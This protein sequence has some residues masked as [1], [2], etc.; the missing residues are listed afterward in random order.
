VPEG[1]RL[2]PPAPPAAQAMFGP[3]LGL[4]ERYAELLAG[5]GVQR[6]LLGPREVP[7]L[8][9]RHLMNC[10]AVAELVPHPCSLV[11]IG[12]GAGLPGIVLAMLLPDVQVVLLEPML[13]RASF[14]GECT[15]LLGLGNTAI[16]RSR[17]QDA[18]GTITADVATARAVAPMER[19]AELALNLVRPGGLVLAIKGAGAA[20]EVERAAPVLRRA[21]ARDVAVVEAGRGKVS[22]PAVVVRMNAG[23]RPVAGARARDGRARGR[24]APQRAARK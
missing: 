8:W 4:A 23:P 15:A 20:Q 7:R 14:L 22:P 17:A 24:P 12:A 13:R 10:A 19:L 5:P 11:D 16:C 3:A 2:A 9:D 21:G 1:V 18:V 6:G